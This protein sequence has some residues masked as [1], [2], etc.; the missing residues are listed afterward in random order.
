MELRCLRNLWE[1]P[2]RLINLRISICIIRWLAWIVKIPI[3]F[4]ID[5]C[6]YLKFI[7]C[8]ANSNIYRASDGKMCSVVCNWDWLVF[9]SSATDGFWAQPLLTGL[10]V[11]IC[12]LLPSLL[13]F[14]VAE[15]QNV[16]LSSMCLR[17]AE[18][19]RHSR[20]KHWWSCMS[21]HT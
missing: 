21:H 8:V 18:I 19:F 10:T 14:I 3:S 7:H 13:L 17:V 2:H 16:G 12:I 11:S 15:E 9:V 6:V 20:R 5:W 1:L 4:S